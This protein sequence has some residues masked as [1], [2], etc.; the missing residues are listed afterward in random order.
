ML[1]LSANLPDA[2]ADLLDLFENAD[3]YDRQVQCVF[4]HCAPP[5]GQIGS[6]SGPECVL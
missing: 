5:Q 4:N 3:N 1:G 2:R 6:R